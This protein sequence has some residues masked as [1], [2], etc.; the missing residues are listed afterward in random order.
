MVGVE[1]IKSNSRS[2]YKSN[3]ILNENIII[4]IS[5][6]IY[7]QSEIGS[8]RKKRV[9]K[10][11]IQKREGKAQKPDFSSKIALPFPPQG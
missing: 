6:N 9:H 11:K 10:Y 3:Q 8:G 4:K 7:L 5:N 1:K 2:Q